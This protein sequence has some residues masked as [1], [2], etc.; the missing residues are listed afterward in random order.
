MTRSIKL[1][2]L[3]INET[4]GVDHPAHLHEGWMV[5]KST[6][7]DTVLDIVSAS[8]TNPDEGGHVEIEVESTPETVEVAAQD[9][10]RKELTD[11]RKA[12]DDMR[13]QKEELEA[14]LSETTEAHEIEKATERAHA[15][16]NVP[17]L[18][19]S[20]FGPLLH[21]LRKVA[22]DTAATIE[23]IFDATS[24]AMSEAGLL[25]EVGAD[26]APETGDAWD[27]IEARAKDLVANGQAADF[28]KAVSVVALNDRELYNRYLSEK[29][30]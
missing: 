13:K 15:W 24:L 2:D 30:F 6:D 23:S 26:V 27:V 3:G 21:E 28:A 22:A 25:K 17:G 12:L 29:G 5:M 10:F 19:P 14:A 4:S 8:T 11:L 16:A 20:T 1:A 7:L 18:D 9:D